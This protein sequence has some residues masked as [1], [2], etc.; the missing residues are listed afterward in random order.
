MHV[1]DAVSLRQYSDCCLFRGFSES[2]RAHITNDNLFNI[3]V[4]PV[5][6][7][8]WSYVTSIECNNNSKLCFLAYL[9]FYGLFTWFLWVL[10]VCFSKK[11]F[12]LK[13]MVTL[14]I[15]ANISNFLLFISFA[16]KIKDWAHSQG[17]EI[18][19]AVSYFPVIF[20]STL[21]ISFLPEG[22]EKNLNFMLEFMAHQFNGGV[23]DALAI[24]LNILIVVIIQSIVII[25]LLR[26]CLSAILRSRNS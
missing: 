18:I 20:P 9:F 7:I 6:D 16:G 25:F 24:W 14:W 26:F 23:G 11:H 13:Q 21:L 22:V 2:L 3:Q 17:V 15:V 1:C 8:C 12:S 10:C 19:V 4:C 5:C